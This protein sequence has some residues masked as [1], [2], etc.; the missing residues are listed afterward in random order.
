ML[1]GKTLWP[2]EAQAIACAV[3]NW[4]EIKNKIEIECSTLKS[5]NSAPSREKADLQSALYEVIACDTTIF[6]MTDRQDALQYL[7]LKYLGWNLV[8]QLPTNANYEQENLHEM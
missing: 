1:V 6:S 8:S 3:A 2:N 5:Q 7:G 4:P